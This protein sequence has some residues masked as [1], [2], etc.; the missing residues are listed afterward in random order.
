MLDY[1]KTSTTKQSDLSVSFDHRVSDWFWPSEF[2]M[3]N[4][5]W[6]QWTLTSCIC[7]CLL[8]LATSVG[9]SIFFKTMTNAMP[10]YPFFLTQVTNVIYIP[11]F[12]GSLI[13]F[14]LLSLFVLLL[15]FK[16]LFS[17]FK[18][19]YLSFFLRAFFPWNYS[20]V[21]FHKLLSFIYFSIG[22]VFYEARFTDHITPSMRAFPKY[23]VMH[24]LL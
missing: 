4:D 2:K 17:I 10:N 15:I 6:I 5:W 13:F 12:F 21:F 1:P 3:M 18:Q 7:R 22:I 20:F 23:K 9:N 14:F 19:E 11:I 24:F 16:I 8:L